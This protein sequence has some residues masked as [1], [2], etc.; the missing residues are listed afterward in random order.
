MCVAR[1]DRAG[2]GLV[3][4]PWWKLLRDPVRAM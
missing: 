3:S 2:L 1:D 4:Q